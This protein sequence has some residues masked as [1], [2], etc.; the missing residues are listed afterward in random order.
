VAVGVAVGVAVSDA[1]AVL[2]DGDVEDPVQASRAAP[3]AADDAGEVGGVGRQ[4]GEGVPVL[5]RVGAADPARRRDADDAPEAGPGARAWV[6]LGARSASGR[7]VPTAA[8]ASR[9]AR[10]A[11]ACVRRCWSLP[12]GT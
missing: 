9:Q 12:A 3:L 11:R 8:R 1:A 6:T 4:A 2:A 10:L 7:G 5:G